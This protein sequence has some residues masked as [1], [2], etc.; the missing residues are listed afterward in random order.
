MFLQLPM[1]NLV[2]CPTLITKESSSCIDVILTNSPQCFK[3]TS[4]QSFSRSDH[5]VIV[6]DFHPRGFK[7]RSP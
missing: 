3:N 2:D 1:I 7:V 6:S 4:A 5:H